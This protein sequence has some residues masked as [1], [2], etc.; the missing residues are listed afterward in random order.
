MARHGRQKGTP[1]NPDLNYYV[2]GFCLLR[3]KTEREMIRH[4]TKEVWV[5]RDGERRFWGKVCP[6]A[7]DRYWATRGS[8]TPG[9]TDR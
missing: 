1:N 3:V 2:C 4:R 7:P 6:S 9:V 5:L 8:A